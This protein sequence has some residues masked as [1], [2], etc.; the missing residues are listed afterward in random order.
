MVLESHKFEKKGDKCIK[1]LEKWRSLWGNRL[2]RY[3]NIK[4]EDSH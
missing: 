2:A 3:D 4:K 1:E